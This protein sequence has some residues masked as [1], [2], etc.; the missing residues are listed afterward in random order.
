LILPIVEILDPIG[1]CGCEQGADSF[2]VFKAGPR[3]HGVLRYPQLIQFGEGQTPY[4]AGGLGNVAEGVV[5]NKGDP[6]EAGI[7]VQE[8]PQ[9][10]AMRVGI[11]H[12][13]RSGE[14]PPL[15]QGVLRGNL[16]RNGK[17]ID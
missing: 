10:V 17:R 16:T 9:R 1:Q 11:C 4:L 3:N 5:P 13:I 15:P 14:N 12:L 6:P 7:R 2:C 8:H